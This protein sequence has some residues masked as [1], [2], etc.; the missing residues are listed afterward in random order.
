MDPKCAP[1]GGVPP[2]LLTQITVVNVSLLSIYLMFL[3]HHY[4][5]GRSHK[6]VYQAF[7][8]DCFVNMD[9]VP[10]CALWDVNSIPMGCWNVVGYKRNAF[11]WSISQRSVSP[12]FERDFIRLPCLFKVENTN[13][14]IL[15][16]V[17]ECKIPEIQITALFL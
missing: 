12:R 3:K 5:D 9:F 10:H 1:V 14:S 15:F 13:R 2:N 17:T 6:K 16:C 4:H 8:L 7:K 11:L